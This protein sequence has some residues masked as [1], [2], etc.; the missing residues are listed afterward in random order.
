ME[1][2]GNHAW[3]KHTTKIGG[4]QTTQHSEKADLLTQ[5]T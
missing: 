1:K 2:N 4:Y 5:P 3:M